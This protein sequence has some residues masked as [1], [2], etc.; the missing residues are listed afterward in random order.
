MGDRIK[1]HKDLDIWQRSITFVAEIY[2][3]TSTVPKEEI[4]CLSAQM[5]RCAIS[6]PSNISEGSARE[7]DQEFVRFLQIARSSA[8]E[9]DTQ[10]IIAKNI[11][12]LGDSYIKI[13]EELL[14]ILKML[15]SLI[16]K[17]KA[18]LS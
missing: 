11:G 12:Y 4:Y 8:V 17:V 7:S 1:T 14:I 6:I 15:S 9:L 13:N 18:R 16:K 5:R 2:K 3:L 10:L